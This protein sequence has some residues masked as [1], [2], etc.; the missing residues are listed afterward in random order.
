[1]LCSVQT[2]NNVLHV[3]GLHTS[4]ELVLPSLGS[5]LHE[6]RRVHVYLQHSTVLEQH[7][8]HAVDIVCDSRSILVGFSDASFQLL[9]WQSQVRHCSITQQSWRLHV[10]SI[11]A[12]LYPEDQPFYLLYAGLARL[13]QRVWCTAG[14]GSSPGA[15]C[16]V[17]LKGKKS[18]FAAGLDEQQRQYIRSRLSKRG[19]SGD[20]QKRVSSD[21]ASWQSAPSRQGSGVSVF[22]HHC[23]TQLHFA[24]PLTP[25]LHQGHRS[26]K[27]LK[28]LLGQSATMLL[29]GVWQALKHA[30]KWRACG[31]GRW[32]AALCALTLSQRG[33]QQRGGRALHRGTGLRPRAA[34]AGSGAH[35]RLLRAAAGG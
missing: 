31:A 14:T 26:S 18:P 12:D 34:A 8:T 28:P 20:L 29:T 5:S 25:I 7:G 2:Y 9:S 33:Q 24:S 32:R 10:N 27:C 35:R 3:Y 21:T 4:K 16:L 17:Q 1:M 15:V 19:S 22:P 30:G 23:A 6:L 11:G 13:R